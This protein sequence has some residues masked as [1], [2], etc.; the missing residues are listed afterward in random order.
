MKQFH[1]VQ[2][3]SEPI[4]LVRFLNYAPEYATEHWIGY[5]RKLGLFLHVFGSPSNT[6]WTFKEPVHPTEELVTKIVWYLE[7]HKDS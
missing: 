7:R 6:D 1:V 3:K 2:V 5:N 4:I